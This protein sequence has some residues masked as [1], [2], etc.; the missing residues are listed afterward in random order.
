MSASSPSGRSRYK[1]THIYQSHRVLPT[2]YY[3]VFSNLTASRGPN[4]CSPHRITRPATPARQEIS[5]P[6]DWI[7]YHRVV[8]I[9]ANSVATVG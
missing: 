8:V 9:G 2:V 7:P 3:G 4:P 1:C 6:S 5:E